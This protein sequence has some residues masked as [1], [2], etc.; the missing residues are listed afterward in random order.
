MANNRNDKD[1]IYNSETDRHVKHEA[2]GKT[3]RDGETV[4][5]GRERVAETTHVRHEEPKKK[6]PWAWLIPL[7][8]LL[9]AIP[10]L[11]NMCDNKDDDDN[12][13]TTTEESTTEKATTEKATT[14][15][16]TTEDATTEDATTEDATTEEASA[17]KF[18]L[19]SIVNFDLAA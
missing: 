18:D 16:A 2:N 17:A 5:E 4:H 11:M 12:K 14:E 19:A 3:V 7:L 10:V 15:D 9:I 13:D 8:I 1:V 6:G